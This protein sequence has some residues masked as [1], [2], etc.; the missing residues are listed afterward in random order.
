MPYAPPPPRST[1]LFHLA[2]LVPDR[3]ELARAG[4]RI[5]DAGWRLSGVADHLVSEA[6]YLDDP[7]GNGIEIYR[8]R[9]RS[10]WS[11]E[12]DELQMAT[13]PLDLEG[14]L[15]SVDEST[16]SLVAGTRLG[17]VHLKVADLASAQSFYTDVIG[18]EITARSYRGAAFLSTGGY[19]H[20]VGINTWTSS[21]MPPP[22]AG[23][24]GLRW[25]ELLVPGGGELTQLAHRA[26]QLGLLVGRADAQLRLV[27]P[28]GNGIVATAAG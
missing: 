21:D 20:H 12:G 19:H 18:L 11:Y 2:I 10:E 7:E 9:P 13:L 8:D 3:A 27:D 28:S 6:L 4:R 16:A 23:T 22:P 14:L 17:H 26:E 1:G 15:E 24:R 5:A 25:F